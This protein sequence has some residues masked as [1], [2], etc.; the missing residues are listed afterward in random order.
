MN[1]PATWPQARKDAAYFAMTTARHFVAAASGQNIRLEDWAIVGAHEPERDPDGLL[2]MPGQY[3]AKLTWRV[4][5]KD[6]ALEVFAS[7][8][9]AEARAE[10]L[11][12]WLPFVFVHPNRCAVVR[13]H[14]LPEHWR[15]LLVEIGF[16][17]LP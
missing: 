7:S 17:G 4:E 9:D 14:R 13:L 5:G 2:G 6:A 16:R 10:S 3:L 15:S 12:P 8:E 1:T 11:R